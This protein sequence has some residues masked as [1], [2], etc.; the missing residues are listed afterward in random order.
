M[1]TKS[2]FLSLIIALSFIF[3]I[4]P[5]NAL[6]I[7]IAPANW[8][9]IYASGINSST[10]NTQRFFSA[11]IE[12][13]ST[14]VPIYNNVP[15][16][17]KEAIQAAIDIWAQYFQ[18]SVPINVSISWSRPIND[19]V[20]ASASAKNVFANFTGAPDKTLYYSSALANALAGRD[21]DVNDPELVI[22]VSSSAN[23]YF[24][25]DGK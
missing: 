25:I 23:W 19:S 15:I 11:Y 10:Q 14:F 5:A 6:E 12:K 13:K 16:I 20:L 21:L 2:Y 3:P 7:K 8:H 9:S 18:S 1:R 22:E 24:G 17:A 4:Q